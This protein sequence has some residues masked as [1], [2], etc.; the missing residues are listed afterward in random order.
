MI[1]MTIQNKQSS[2]APRLK[3]LPDFEKKPLVNEIE[4]VLSDSE[5]RA[6]DLVSLLW[7]APDIDSY[8]N[9]VLKVTADGFEGRVKEIMASPEVIA[10]YT[11][12]TRNNI[13]AI[14]SMKAAN[15]DTYAKVA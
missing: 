7:W 3:G 12:S 9:K 1:Y 6:L 11:K 15:D 14:L 2:I 10:A 13:D 5:N 4:T 8:I